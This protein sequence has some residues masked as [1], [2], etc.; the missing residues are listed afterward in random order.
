MRR[1]NILLIL[2]VLVATIFAIRWVKN[3]ELY[4]PSEIRE[5]FSLNENLGERGSNYLI[6]QYGRPQYPG[7]TRMMVV[8][9][10]EG[11]VRELGPVRYSQRAEELL[12]R[13]FFRDRKGGTF[14]DVGAY[15]YRIYNNT[16]YLEEHLDWQGI[17]VDALAEFESGYLEHRPRTRYYTFFVSDTSDDSAQLFVSEWNKRLSS[18]I[19]DLFLKEDGSYKGPVSEREVSTITLDDLLD[20]SGVDELDLLTIDIELWEPKALS[21]FDIQRFAPEL[22]CVEAHLPIREEIE[23]YFKERGYNRIDQYLLV[24]AVNWYYT[25][26]GLAVP[27]LLIGHSETA[28]LGPE[29]TQ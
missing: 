4:R 26:E 22:V 6:W 9:A 12:I 23:L 20:S 7:H 13:H 19:Q 27:P 18:G 8:S 11:L 21:G 2:L 10:I 17:A 28:S 5:E 1:R 16:Y 15:H 3:P 24:D 14:L 29:Q 25:P